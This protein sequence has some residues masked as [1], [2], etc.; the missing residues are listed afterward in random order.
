MGIIQRIVER[1]HACKRPSAEEWRALF[2]AYS[3]HVID[4][5]G[6][7]PLVCHPTKGVRLAHSRDI[8]DNIAPEV[9]RD[10]DEQYRLAA[11]IIRISRNRETTNR[12]R[13][14]WRGSGDRCEA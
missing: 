1:V 7:N 13:P 14:G 11:S 9:A 5:E 6:A 12:L 3:K 8:L 2:V 4:M 10:Q